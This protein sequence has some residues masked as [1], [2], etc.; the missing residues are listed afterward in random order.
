MEKRNIEKYF[1]NLL[2]K[3]KVNEQD[4]RAICKRR[5]ILEEEVE[6]L[7]RKH[8]FFKGMLG[9]YRKIPIKD[10]KLRNAVSVI[11]KKYAGK[12]VNLDLATP[13]RID[14]IILD[15]EYDYLSRGVMHTILY[16]ATEY[17]EYLDEFSIHIHGLDEIMEEEGVLTEIK[18]IIFHLKNLANDLGISEEAVILQD[19]YMNYL[20][21]F[22]KTKPN[23]TETVIM[24]TL[25]ENY[26]RLILLENTIELIKKEIDKN[27]QYSI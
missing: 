21:I 25:A 1:K 6:T 16:V 23:K 5:R 11:N 27:I 19:H 9:G 24:E 8:G 17:V 18:D 13:P 14:T 10:E 7:F 3:Q 15:D 4:I 26:R 20:K 2:K 22:F 12:K